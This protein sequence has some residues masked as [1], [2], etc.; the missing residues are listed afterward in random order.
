ML[1]ETGVYSQITLGATDCL[2]HDKHLFSI[3]LSKIS[4]IKIPIAVHPIR[5]DHPKETPGSLIFKSV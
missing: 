2:S 3:K 1:L 4:L 5:Y